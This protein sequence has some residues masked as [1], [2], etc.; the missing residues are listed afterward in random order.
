MA[1]SVH[2]SSKLSALA[3]LIAV[4]SLGLS[5]AILLSKSA[6][7]TPEVRE[8]AA[9]F[10]P[11]PNLGLLLQSIRPGTAT[12]FCEGGQGSGW[13][14]P[15]RPRGKPTV[16]TTDVTW[17]KF[18]GNV[19]TN[20]HVIEDC[21]DS[22]EEIRVIANGKR[23]DSR[24]FNWDKQTDLALVAISESLAPL[25]L[26]P[27]PVSGWWSMVFGTALG[28]PGSVATGNIINLDGALISTTSAVNPGNSGGP[29][30]NSL[31]QVIGTV[32]GSDVGEGAQSWNYAAG[33][34]MLCRKILS[35]RPDEFGWAIVPGSVAERS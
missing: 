11:P 6:N 18:P 23:Q 16:S 32:T 13:I 19:I 8:G 28:S 33:L 9:V 30:L 10:L 3:L 26:G 17:E 24:L 35:C 1:A 12:I 2:S 4:C 5:V 14:L 7:Q 22:P 20:H 29:L 25:D 21:I 15:E 27:R 31:G 34:P